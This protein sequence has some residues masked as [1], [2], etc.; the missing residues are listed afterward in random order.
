MIKLVW[1]E[2][3]RALNLK[4]RGIDFADLLELFENETATEVDERFDYGEDRLLSFGLLL[5]QVLAVVHT[6]TVKGEDI[7]IR[8][9]SARKA[10]KYEQESYCKKVRD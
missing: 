7:L 2:S 6:E 4:R 1:D 9:I 8:V 5:G 10:D 3:K